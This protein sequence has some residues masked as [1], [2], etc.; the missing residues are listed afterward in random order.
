MLECKWDLV[1]KRDVD[2]FLEVLK[3]S[4]EFGVDTPEGRQVEQGII[5]VFAGNAFDSKEKVR[6]KDGTE[7]SL[8]S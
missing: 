4:K 2:N 3:W 6:L 7:I 5:G 1:R 8:P